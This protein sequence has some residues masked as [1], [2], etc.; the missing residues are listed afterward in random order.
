MPSLQ[1]IG[2][3]LIEGLNARAPEIWAGK[4][5]LET[6]GVK[7][8]VLHALAQIAAIAKK[9]GYHGVHCLV[10]SADDFLDIYQDQQPHFFPE[11]DLIS[12]LPPVRGANEFMLTLG[13]RG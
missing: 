6:A 10:F 8:P 9:G 12:L 1:Q 5:T 11:L 3:H 13:K 4:A 7:R 2:A